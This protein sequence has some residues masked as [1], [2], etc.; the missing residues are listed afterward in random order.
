MPER[1]FVVM[2]YIDVVD[3]VGF[4]ESDADAENYQ[5]LALG[6]TD[7][8]EKTHSD[9]ASSHPFKY[10]GPS[11]T[12]AS[13]T[14]KIPSPNPGVKL[15]SLAERFQFAIHPL[16]LRPSENF[17]GDSGLG[18]GEGIYEPSPILLKLGVE[19]VGI[20][21]P[22]NN[23]GGGG[24]FR[25]LST[26]NFHQ[27]PASYNHGPLTCLEP[28]FRRARG[29]KIYRGYRGCWSIGGGDAGSV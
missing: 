8:S 11:S 29:V 14:S 12:T 7:E 13:S 18:P 20:S 6:D 25:P 4:P 1:I 27:H 17:D 21:D 15:A 26:S 5:P 22:D 24:V 9:K 10:P 28:R 16:A 2:N 23:N 3:N 19:D